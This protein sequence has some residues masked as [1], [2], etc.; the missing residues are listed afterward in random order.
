[1]HVK[2]DKGNAIVIINKEDYLSKTLDFIN[3]NK[4]IKIKKDPTDKYQKE[5][6]EVIKNSRY[7]FNNANHNQEEDLNNIK[8]IKRQAI[9]IQP[10]APRIKKSCQ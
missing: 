7:I 3:K 2:A 8:K 6:K 5:I 1:M 4:F 9:N 10:T